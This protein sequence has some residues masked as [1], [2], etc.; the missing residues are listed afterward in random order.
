MGTGTEEE[1]T[2]CPLCGSVG[3][4]SDQHLPGTPKCVIAMLLR[5]TSLE[6]A[7]RPLARVGRL[8]ST[9]Q[10]IDDEE[11]NLWSVSGPT[12]AG[13]IAITVADCKR[14]AALLKE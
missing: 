6:A 2:I 5:I 8:E 7:L 14:A 13:K 12:L 1:T 9:F 3:P 10:T 11:V 4:A